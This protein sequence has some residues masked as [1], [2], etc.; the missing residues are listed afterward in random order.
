VTR[1]EIAPSILSADFRCLE[2]EVQAAQ[3][4]GAD[5]IHCDVMDGAFVNNITFG[6]L[7]VEAVRKAV[8][9]PLDVHLMIQDPLRYADDFCSAGANTLTVHAEVCKDL[10]AVVGKIRGHGVRPGIT[11][12]PEVPVDLFIRELSLFEQVLIMT[13]PAGR[14]GQTFVM[15]TVAKIKRVYD[16]AAASGRAVDIEVD[17]GINDE[18]AQLC[19]A[20]GANVFVAGNFVFNSDDYRGRISSIREAAQRGFR[21]IAGR[22]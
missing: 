22:G 5:R 18:T 9:I 15:S 17:G 1:I 8:S 11:V 16:E 7:V 10:A 13:V 21:T 2:R 6:P 3:D 12:N 14:G 19:A 4:A 20:N